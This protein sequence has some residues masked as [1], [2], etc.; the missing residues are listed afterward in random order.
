MKKNTACGITMDS[1]FS[2]TIIDPRGNSVADINAGLDSLFRMYNEEEQYY[3]ESQNYLVSEFE[4]A[5]PEL[6]ANHSIFDSEYYWWW[7]LLI[8]RLEDPFTDLKPNWIY[9]ILTQNNINSLIETANTIV[10]NKSTQRIGN[11]IELN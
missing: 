2:E 11:I 7:L 6:I 5:Y 4:E 1:F 9:S 8:N 10:E 3:T